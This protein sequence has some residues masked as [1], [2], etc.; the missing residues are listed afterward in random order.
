MSAISYPTLEEAASSPGAIWG[1]RRATQR[2]DSLVT[3]KLINMTSY[4]R[5]NDSEDETVKMNLS[6]T[7]PEKEKKKRRRKKILSKRG[8][9]ISC[10]WKKEL[11]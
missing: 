5:P 2:G 11:R 8:I 4:E 7:T 6:V 3:E 10:T 1:R 9:S